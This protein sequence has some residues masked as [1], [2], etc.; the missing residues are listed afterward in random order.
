MANTVDD[1][2]AVVHLS[3]LALGI[4]FIPTMNHQ[5]VHNHALSGTNAERIFYELVG[6]HKTPFTSMKLPEY[7]Q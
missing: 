4:M 5:I 3:Q 6:L 7:M 2:A 1:L